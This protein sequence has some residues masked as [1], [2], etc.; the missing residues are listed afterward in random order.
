MDD[1]HRSS[2][3]DSNISRQLAP[4]L[5]ADLTESEQGYNM[6]ADIPG[7]NKEDIELSIEDGC[8]VIRAEKKHVHEE[9]NDRVHSM[10]RSFGTIQ[11]RM[12]LPSDADVD[13]ATS[14]LKNGVLC[15]SF[16]KKPTSSTKK[17]TISS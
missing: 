17:L 16:P 14:E 2:R 4:V 12:P 10:E 3:R 5:R 13:K 1:R 6:H 7:I 15:V 8:L 11:R 9:K